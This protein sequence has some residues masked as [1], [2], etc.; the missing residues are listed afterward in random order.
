MLFNH[1]AEP[2]RA[3]GF[4]SM[5]T[6]VRPGVDRTRSPTPA[7][8]ATFW[9]LRNAPWSSDGTSHWLVFTYWPADVATRSSRS[10]SRPASGTTA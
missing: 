4:E 6:T 5:Q 10:D 9:L 3:T 8:P 2:S 1:H 7:G